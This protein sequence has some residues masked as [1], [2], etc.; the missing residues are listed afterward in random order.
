MDTEVTPTTVVVES[1]PE[2][3]PV[4]ATETVVAAETA[5]ALAA[6][7]AASAELQAAERVAA[8]EEGADEWR[9]QTEMRMAT[10]AET[11][12]ALS[13]RLSEL[14]SREDAKNSLANA[15]MA[16]L[17]EIESQLPKPQPNPSNPPTLSETESPSP[18]LGTAG[19]VTA[20]PLAVEAGVGVGGS[21]PAPSSTRRSASTAPREQKHRWI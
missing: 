7:T 13:Q 15:L 3:E 6:A 18:I 12:G 2:P 1:E 14:S 9:T 8:V 20:G 21:E 11:A 17:D 4:G 19:E 16:R 5:V 10:L